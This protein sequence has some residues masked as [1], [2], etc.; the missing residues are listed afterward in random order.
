[1]SD[2]ST[3]SSKSV[4]DPFDRLSEVLFGLITVLTFTS[5]LGVTQTGDDSI[6]LMLVGA[7][8][9]NL[10]WGIIDAFFYLLGS[11]AEKGSQ[12]KAYRA[13]RATTDPVEAQKLIADALP[14]LVASVLQPAE[15]AAVHE[16]LKQLPEPPRKAKLRKQ[17]WVG[18]SS[19][20]ALVFLSTF[21]PTIP[22]M[23][24]KNP[25]TA[26]LVSNVIAVTLLF[27]TGFALARVT[28]RHPIR[29]GLFMVVVGVL[30]VAIA[31][32]LGG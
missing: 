28:G 19:I 1:M 14:P 10:A 9:C 12:L 15:F 2:N 22:F 30:L 26:L 17:D 11:L 23:L 8:G 24:M 21:P 13:V 5:S 7:L 27:V 18:A 31:N 29:S 32:R 25:V 20:F 4:L 16:R 3:K 6:H